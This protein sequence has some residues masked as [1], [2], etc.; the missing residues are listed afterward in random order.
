MLTPIREFV[1]STEKFAKIGNIKVANSNKDKFANHSDNRS[2]MA[3]V[4]IVNLFSLTP[5]S[6]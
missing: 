2:Y 3:D 4:N 5:Q 6:I 1:K